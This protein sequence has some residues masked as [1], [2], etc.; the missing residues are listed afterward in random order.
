MA[1]NGD[2][3][4]APKVLETLGAMGVDPDSLDART[5]GQLARMEPA[6]AGIAAAHHAAKA[7][8][9]A[10]MLTIEGVSKASGVS[11]PTIHG[12]KVL[13]GYIEARRA[14]ERVFY[15]NEVV[16]SLRKRLREAEERAEKLVRRD[17]ELV[18][19]LAELERVRERNRRLEEYIGD[20][21]P[22]MRE[23]L[24][25]M[26]RIIPFPDGARG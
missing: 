14:E 5:V 1:E 6:I 24:D 20:L 3:G 13:M 10:H 17:G 15:E 9:R 26:G 2:S 8:A 21:P 11:R 25:A 19:A 22:Y 4:L 18:V 12:K 23:E 7:D 16:A